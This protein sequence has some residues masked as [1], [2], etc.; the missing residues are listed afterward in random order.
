M[1]SLLIGL[2]ILVVIFSVVWWILSMI[3]IPGPFFW[4][5]R[6]IFAIIFLIA[7]IS[8]LTGSWTFPFGHAHLR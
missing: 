6:V 7:L 1:L 5:V 4:V 8:F 3:P 2:L